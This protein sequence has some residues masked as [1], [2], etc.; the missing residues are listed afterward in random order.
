[1][2]LSHQLYKEKVSKDL[3]VQMGYKNIYQVPK[4]DKIVL[5]MGLGTFLKGGG[6]LEDAQHDLSL[7]AGQTPCITK[8]RR[9][10][11]G[12]KIRAGSPGGLKV[13]LRGLRMFEF[14]DRLIY[15][16]LPRVRDFKGVRAK[17][18]DGRGGV[19]LGIREHFVFPEITHG[20]AG[21]SLGMDIHLITTAQTPKETQALLAAMKIPFLV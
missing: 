9:S 15:I 5:S 20:G 3:M 7:V 21:R 17:S 6:K 4:L 16:A 12:F 13:T 8:F 2:S 14:L 18:S 1:M 10:V 19:S 11:A